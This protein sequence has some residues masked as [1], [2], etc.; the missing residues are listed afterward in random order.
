MMRHGTDSRIVTDVELINVIRI[1]VILY[2]T[3]VQ[4]GERARLTPVCLRIVLAELRDSFT[5]VRRV[6]PRIRKM[7]VIRSCG[8]SCQALVETGE[9]ARLRKQL[10]GTK[11]R[12]FMR[13]RNFTGTIILYLKTG[14]WGDHRM[15][16]GIMKILLAEIKTVHMTDLCFSMVRY[17]GERGIMN[18]VEKQ[19]KEIVRCKEM[20]LCIRMLGFVGQKRQVVLREKRDSECQK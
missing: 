17:R 15:I 7:T 8:N 14:R 9:R 1:R 11:R 20:I 10:T 13:V 12:V 16:I 19:Y 3:L 6:K 18:G 5:A 2:L 4:T